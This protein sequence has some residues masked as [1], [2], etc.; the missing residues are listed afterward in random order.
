MIRKKYI[1]QI[2]FPPALFSVLSLVFSLRQE[3]LFPLAQTF[4]RLITYSGICLFT[5]ET[6]LNE[7]RRRGGKSI[8]VLLS[9]SNNR[10]NDCLSGI[11][12]STNHSNRILSPRH[13]HQSWENIL[14]WCSAWMPEI[15]E[16]KEDLE[17]LERMHFVHYFSRQGFRL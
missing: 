8:Q 16:K 1:W 15:H 6:A 13:Q 4:D 17:F 2:C 3:R 5:A 12:E 14:W 10:W 11:S 7:Q 9:R